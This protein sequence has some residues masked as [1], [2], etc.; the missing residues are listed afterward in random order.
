MFVL[1]VRVDCQV[2]VVVS[3]SKGYLQ[4]PEKKPIIQRPTIPVLYYY[5]SHQFDEQM[6]N[7][8]YLEDGYT[9]FTD[10][11]GNGQFTP[12]NVFQYRI[13]CG[14][15]PIADPWVTDAR[16]ERSV[17]YTTCYELLRNQNTIR[18]QASGLHGVDERRL[19]PIP[20]SQEWNGQTIEAK[21]QGIALKHLS[22]C[23]FQRD[24]PAQ[25]LQSSEPK[26]CHLE[27]F[28]ASSSAQAD[29]LAYSPVNN[30][31]GPTLQRRFRVPCSYCALGDCIRNCSNGEMATGF[32]NIV[33][34]THPRAPAPTLI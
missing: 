22:T 13:K 11:S 26:A 25:C 2:G 4:L 24:C 8:A 7:L 32:A 1:L 12:P 30:R 21:E 23:C 14:S 27:I 15:T 10:G 31:G 9:G 20:L 29:D 6:D 28:T 5:S 16:I 19:I 18:F 33:A 17:Q 3:V 34:S